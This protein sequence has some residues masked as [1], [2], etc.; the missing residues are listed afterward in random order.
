MSYFIVSANYLDR[1]SEYRWLVR[2][3]ED[4]VSKARAFKHVTCNGVMFCPSEEVERGFG[5]GVIAQAQEGLTLYEP[6]NPE[7]SPLDQ[8]VKCTPFNEAEHPELAS[9]TRLKFSVNS[10]VYKDEKKERYVEVV[11]KLPLLNLCSDGRMICQL[12]A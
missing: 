7:P 4:P 10:F 1:D 9:G 12:S 2:R 11:N 5:C 8:Y 6:E 3:P